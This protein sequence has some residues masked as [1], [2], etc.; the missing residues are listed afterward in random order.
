MF[1][2]WV[3][4][5]INYEINKVPLKE[6]NKNYRCMIYLIKYSKE[7]LKALIANIHKTYEY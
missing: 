7:N 2:V 5:F 4:Y 1:G 6:N 3:E